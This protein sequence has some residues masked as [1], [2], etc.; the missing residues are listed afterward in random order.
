MESSILYSLWLLNREPTDNA[1]K[2]SIKSL[3]DEFR[4]PSVEQVQLFM[5]K[6]GW[7]QGDTGNPNLAIYTKNE[8]L[9]TVANNESLEDYDVCAIRFAENYAAFEG[10]SPVAVFAELI[11]EQ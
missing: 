5:K 7:T 10:I 3:V 4:L 8:M 6:R 2:T 11:S 1:T 9:F